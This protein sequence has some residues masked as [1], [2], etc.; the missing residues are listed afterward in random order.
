MSQSHPPPHALS[1]L[2]P[3]WAM[4]AVTML[5]GLVFAWFVQRTWQESP[6]DSAHFANVHSTMG[7]LYSQR[8]KND[9]AAA[10]F[11]RAI[12][13]QPDHAEAFNNLGNVYLQQGKWDDAVTQYKQAFK[14]RPKYAD[15]QNNLGLA[16]LQKGRLD[17][18]I[19]HFLAALDLRPDYADARNNLGY[20]LLQKGRYKEA[21]EHFRAAVALNS[22][23]AQAHHNLALCLYSQGKV[24]EAL[25]SYQDA[26]QIN[27]RQLGSIN[28]L[29]WV[30]A[31]SSDDRLRNGSRAFELA[32][33]ANSLS[34]GSDP[35]IMHTLAAAL[36]ELGRYEEAAITARRA[37]RLTDGNP[38]LADAIQ[39]QIQLYDARR[40]MREDSPAP[41]E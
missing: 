1:P 37:L 22:G 10:Q 35:V 16:L 34:G 11:Q 41:V 39:G 19:G 33:Q 15:A 20:A 38:N 23:I 9:E 2:I 21:E 29:A 12:E 17:E 18:A 26:I 5:A 6:H 24:P 4:A 36:A 13:L 40:P 28:N 14:L 3:A 7:I 30:L 25:A 27:S 8:G 32:Q 31:T